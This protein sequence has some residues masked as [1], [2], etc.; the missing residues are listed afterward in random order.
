MIMFPV[1]LVVGGTQMQQKNWWYTGKKFENPWHRVPA[2]SASALAASDALPVDSPQWMSS[3]RIFVSG[4]VD[5][6]RDDEEIC[7]EGE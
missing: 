4:R 1:S 3:S 7:A 2:G 6:V 5:G